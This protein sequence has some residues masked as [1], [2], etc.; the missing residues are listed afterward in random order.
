MQFRCNTFRRESLACE[1]LFVLIEMDKS[2]CLCA[3]DAICFFFLVLISFVCSVCFI[4]FFAWKLY[5]SLIIKCVLSR[6]FK[7]FNVERIHSHA[8]ANVE[9]W[10]RSHRR[11]EMSWVREKNSDFLL[12]IVFSAHS[13]HSWPE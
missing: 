1:L 12:G 11:A 5:R 3:V 10:E 2:T 7:P 4:L 9:N 8:V 13:K 6:R